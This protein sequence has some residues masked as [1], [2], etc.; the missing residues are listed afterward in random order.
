MRRSLAALVAVIALLASAC[1]G[2]AD[3]TTAADDPDAA[4]VEETNA[5]DADPEIEV[6]EGDDADAE[7][8]EQAAADDST[9]EE[10]VIEPAAVDEPELEVDPSDVFDPEFEA[11]CI[12]FFELEVESA[13]V[14][15]PVEG[16]QIV[17]DAYSDL[18]E[19]SP[20][21]DLTADLTLIA[22]VSA[23]LS[24]FMSDPAVDFLD[25]SAEALEFVNALST[26]E[27]EAAAGRVESRFTSQCGA[28]GAVEETLDETIVLDGPGEFT[29][30]IEGGTFDVYEIEVPEGTVLTVTMIDLT[31]AV[32]PLLN[33]VDPDG[34]E[35]TNDDHSNTDPGTTLTS[36]DSQVI[37]GSGEGSGVGGVYMIQARSF[38]GG[39]TGDYLLT[40]EF[41]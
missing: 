29:G 18:S 21:P 23:E 25:P 15:D 35:F 30:S 6:D 5:G 3:E 34:A 11:F 31:G 1:G 19:L 13:N 39:S 20:D 32:D 37:L 28:E 22:G 33:I 27:V 14:L 16:F 9:D 40:V 24:E 10:P 4:V 26:P 36:F 12:R 41:G 8:T 38:Q 2:S 7:E 17:A